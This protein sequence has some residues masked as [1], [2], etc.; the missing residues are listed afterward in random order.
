[1]PPDEATTEACA[2]S[3]LSL[4]KGA[5]GTQDASPRLG[6][7]A[8]PGYSIGVTNGYSIGVTNS[9]SIGVTN[10]YS[11]GVINWK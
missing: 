11:I 2:L 9:Y 4:S 5:Q 3:T 8:T 10:G 1:M 7:G 6:N